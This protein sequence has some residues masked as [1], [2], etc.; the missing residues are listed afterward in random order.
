MASI[1]NST[2]FLDIPVIATH[3][4]QFIPLNGEGWY[5]VQHQSFLNDKR[6]GNL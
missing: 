4:F 5:Q 3:P 6:Y 2:T 1:I